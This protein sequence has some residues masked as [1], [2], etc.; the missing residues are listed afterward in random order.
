MKGEVRIRY[1]ETINWMDISVEEVLKGDIA[2]VK[3]LQTIL[4]DAA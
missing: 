4:E 1:K 2:F 3:S